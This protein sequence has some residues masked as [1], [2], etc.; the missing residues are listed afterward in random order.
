MLMDSFY[1][2]RIRTNEMSFVDALD[3]LED[4]DY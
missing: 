1:N 4:Y 3:T 2:W